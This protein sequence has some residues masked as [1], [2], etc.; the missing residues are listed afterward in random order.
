[1]DQEPWVDT[2]TVAKHLGFGKALV[3]R[4]AKQGE[5]PSVPRKSGRRTYLRFKISA[6]DAAWKAR[7]TAA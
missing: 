2:K 5:I 7:E 1:M 4:M 3:T 6:V